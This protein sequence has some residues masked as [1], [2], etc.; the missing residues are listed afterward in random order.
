MNDADRAILDHFTSMRAK[1]L[2]MLEAAPEEMLGRVAHAEQHP[3]GWQFAHIANGV[4]W[5]MHH[6]MRDGGGWSPEHACERD[7]IVAGLTSSRDR[8]LSFFAAE[9]G[10]AMSSDVSYPEVDG[11][12]STWVGREVVLYL[13]AHELHHL[14][15]GEL[16]LWQWGVTDLPAFP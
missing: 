16:A 11:S 7:E 12:T 13:T 14:S 2:E 8:L 5:W 9:D 1:T 4:D 6:V 3:L 15:R 10:K